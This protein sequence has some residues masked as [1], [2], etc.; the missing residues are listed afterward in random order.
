MTPG[1]ASG[2]QTS[3][4]RGA[5]TALLA[6]RAAALAAKD[7]NAWLASLADTGSP[8]AAAQA[9]LFD[10][11]VALP[12]AG[13]TA[14]QLT[15]TPTTPPGS[16]S[17]TSTL[18]S[19]AA[20]PA[21]TYVAAATLAYRFAGYDQG[22]R[23]FAVSYVVSP[24]SSGW[25][26]SGPGPGRTDPQP[27][28]LVG[29]TSVSSPA[30]LVIGDVAPARLEAYRAL[31]DAAQAPIEA[32]WGQARPSVIVAP[33]TMAELEAQLGRGSYAGIAQVAAITDGPVHTGEPAQSDR[34][35]LNPDVMA[36]LSADGRKVVVTHELTHVTIRGSTTRPVPIWLS[37]G[38][39]DAVAYSGTGLAPRA[40]AADLLQLVRDGKGPTALPTSSDFD[41]SRGPIDPTYNAAWLAVLLIHDRFGQEKLTDV[42]RA[43]SGGPTADATVTGSA[44]DLTRQAFQTVL[45]VSQD[46]FVTDWKAYL[47]QLARP[48][49]PGL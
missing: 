6:K 3:E 8:F 45:G 36:T 42:Y 12:V 46:D 27:F 25:R 18:S 31:G 43:V 47:E 20:G 34:V 19:P 28:D 48:S 40:V 1:G 17:S 10:R 24:A 49:P 38:Y 14:R 15:L 32:A 41:P 4:V 5:V 39:A 23:S 44:D 16:A 2:D 13:L 7:K 9:S 22:E 29:A 37:E 21:G 33:G 11:L 35:Y 26:L 30:T